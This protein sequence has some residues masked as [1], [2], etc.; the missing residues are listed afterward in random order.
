MSPVLVKKRTTYPCKSSP[1]RYSARWSILSWCV[2]LLRYWCLNVGLGALAGTGRCVC[3]PSGS[4]LSA[5][6]GGTGFGSCF[7]GC[8]PARARCTPATSSK[9]SSRANASAALPL[10]KLLMAAY[11][12][13]RSVPA[14]PVA[15][16][17][18][19]PNFSLPPMLTLQLLPAPPS[20]D[21]HLYSCPATVPPGIQAGTSVLT[22]HSN[23]S[24]SAVKLMGGSGSR[25]GSLSAMRTPACFGGDGAHQACC[26]QVA[27]QWH[28]TAAPGSSTASATG[29][30]ANTGSYTD[31]GRF[32]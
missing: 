10:G 27:M 29:S 23:A 25:A 11:R 30:T 6:T 21:A 16:S 3:Q 8:V 14:S 15:K 18:Q 31:T 9:P 12:L 4:L 28:S 7:G 2:S 22:R 32:R 24:A 5:A 19:Q 26:T 13:I 20:S 17:A 1:T